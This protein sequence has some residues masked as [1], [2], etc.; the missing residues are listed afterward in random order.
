MTP[1]TYTTQATN[2]ISALVTD[3][4]TVLFGALPAVLGLV[5]AL[6]G[7]FFVYRLIKR[8]IGAPK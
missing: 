8:S 1:V 3:I 7:V 2:A 6:I 5:A 4:G